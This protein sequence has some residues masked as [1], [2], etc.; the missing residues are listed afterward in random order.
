M[1]LVAGTTRRSEPGKIY[2]ADMAIMHDPVW[3]ADNYG[4]DIALIRL[5]KEIKYTD[6]IQSIELNE[7]Y[8]EPDTDVTLAGWGR[9][10]EDGH[11]VDDLH[12]IDLVSITQKE[13]QE[14]HKHKVR[15]YM[16]CTYTTVGEGSCK[17]DSGSPLLLNGK[18]AGL[19]SWGKHCG[20]GYPN[21]YTRVASFIDW[22]QTTMEK[23]S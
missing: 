18:V 23:N 19:S 21:V 3:D 22:V 12:W 2:H 1:T 6:L 13:C 9:I 4:N 11:S 17:G 5:T 7:N 8:V 20:G 15:D 16:M 14:R 10:D